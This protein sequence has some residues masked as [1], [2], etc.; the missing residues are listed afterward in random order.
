MKLR[1]ASTVGL[2]FFG[3]GNTS[4]A[5]APCP[6]RPTPPPCCADG[7]CH[8]NPLTFGWYETR[9][10]QWPIQPFEPGAP[11]TGEQQLQNEIPRFEAPPA[12]EEERRAPPPT[13]PREEQPTTAVPGGGPAAPEGNETRMPPNTP[14]PPQPGVPTEP[15]GPRRFLPPY[16][17]QTPPQGP[18]NNTGPTGE[19]DPPPALPF[20][21]APIQQAGPLREAN[22]LPVTPS[23]QQ[24]PATKVKSSSD[25]P[26]PA[27][28][29]TLAKLSY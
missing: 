10:R 25:D 3:I 14:P 20:G 27:L 17:P 7:R 18:L 4:L 24:M 1:I 19:F 13:T 11:Q 2:L 26:P 23:Q 12:E 29:V 21:P 9:W 5:V 8:P 22:R 28:P 6:D 15:A 16:Q